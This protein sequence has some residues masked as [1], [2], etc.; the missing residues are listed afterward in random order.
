MLI[1]SEINDGLRDLYLFITKPMK[2][3]ETTINRQFF[4]KFLTLSRH[5]L[6]RPKFVYV[7]ANKKQ[8][9]PLD[10]CPYVLL[11]CLVFNNKR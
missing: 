5:M 1:L 10:R 8:I 2:R 4:F 9:I 6:Y 7:T 11:F 3:S